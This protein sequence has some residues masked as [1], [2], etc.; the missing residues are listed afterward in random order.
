MLQNLERMKSALTEWAIKE[1]LF[2]D[3][4]FYSCKQWNDRGE[5]IQ[6]DALLVLVIDSSGLYN[7]LNGGNDTEELEDLVESFGFYYELGYAWSM[8]FYPL[9]D[10]DYSRLSGTYAQKLQDKRWTNKSNLVKQRA[11]NRCQDCNTVASLQAHHCYYTNMRAGY[12]PWEYPLSAFRALCRECHEKRPVPEIRIR[13]LLAQLTQDQLTGLING[14]DN[15]FNRFEKN[16]F[17]EFMQKATFHE[18]HMSAALAIL[19]KNTDIY[20]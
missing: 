17:I 3:A 4:Q 9:D 5:K 11:G 18:N 13:A 16:S 19:K 6:N 8:G 2:H 10:Y 14:L 20:D 7:L 1:G 12:E 15:A